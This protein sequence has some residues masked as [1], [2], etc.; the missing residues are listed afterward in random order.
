MVLAVKTD[1]NADLSKLAWIKALTPATQAGGTLLGLNGP[2]LPD[3][4]TWAPLAAVFEI[5]PTAE[6]LEITLAGWNYALTDTS[7]AARACW[8][9]SRKARR[10]PF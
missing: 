7:K 5:P 10:A 6:A 4:A 9:G 2:E 1:T 3:R 8:V